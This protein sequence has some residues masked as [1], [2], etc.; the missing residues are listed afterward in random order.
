MMQSPR[1]PFIHNPQNGTD[2]HS[3]RTHNW[4]ILAIYPAPS[5]RA[6]LAVGA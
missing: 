1:L 5:K 3:V 4:D 6:S 2:P